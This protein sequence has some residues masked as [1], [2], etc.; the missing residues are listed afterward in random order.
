MTSAICGVVGVLLG[1]GMIVYG[2]ASGATYTYRGATA[3]LWIAGLVF[4]A[5]GIWALVQGIMELSQQPSKS[6]RRRRD[7]EDD[8]DDDRPRRRSRR[9][10]DDDEDERPRPRRRLRDD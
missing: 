2:V 6:P 8:E 1:L 10:N 3:P 9:R 7:D 4:L 5:V